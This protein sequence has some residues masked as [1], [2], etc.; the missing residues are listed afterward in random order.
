MIRAPARGRRRNVADRILPIED[1]PRL[2]AMIGEYP[3]GAG[4]PGSAFAETRRE[5]TP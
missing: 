2:A 5:R 3:G 1:D 4:A